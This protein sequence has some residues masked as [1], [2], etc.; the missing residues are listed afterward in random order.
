MPALRPAA[1]LA[2]LLLLSFTGCAKRAPATEP[3]A[4]ALDAAAERY[5]KLVL[6]VGQH[7]PDYVDA[8][9]GPAAWAEEAKATKVP[10]EALATRAAEVHQALEALPVP[11][12]ALVAQRRRF[13]LGQV[14]SLAA[15]VRLL[16]GE[17]LGFDEESEALYGAR[18]P[19]HTEAEFQQVH[20]E[21]EKLLP[22]PEPLPARMEAFRKAF[23]VPPQKLEQVLRTAIEEARRR[24][25]AHIPLPEGEAVTLELVTGKTWGGYNWYQGNAKSLVQINTD[26][27]T[28]I[29]RAIDVGAH[30]SYPGHHVYNAL[31]EQHLLRERGWVEFSV[32]PLYSPMSF[33]AEGSANYGVEVAFPDKEAYLRDVLMPLAGLDPSR[34]GQY[35]RVEALLEK[36]AYADLEAA[37]GYLDGRLTREQARDYLV[38]NRLTSPERASKLLTNIDATRTYIINY[39]LG[40]DLVAH[41]VERQGGT[42]DA[43]ERRWQ[44]FRELLSAPLLPGDLR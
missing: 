43:P 8:Y 23:V 14:S 40:R 30:E 32:Y 37:R 25:R 31:L 36:L 17:K 9:F 12:E 41:H 28:F 39:S 21:L 24:T 11:G 16:R 13:L 4:S 19:V 18:A 22:G 29:S 44:V 5:V 33:I 20:A 27:P 42:A 15:R 34:A 6:A 38:R 35:V 3:R 1:V 2:A 26:L 7:D 10:L